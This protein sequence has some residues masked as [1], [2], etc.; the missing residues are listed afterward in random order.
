MKT[1]DKIIELYG[2]SIK[3][4]YYDRWHQYFVN[5]K[6]SIGVTTITGLIDKSRALIYWAVGLT[7]NHLIEIHNGGTTITIEHIEEASKL[8]AQRKKEAADLGTEVHLWCEKY[9]SYM[10]SKNK[11]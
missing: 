8:H 6:K 4:E 1:P 7:K 5:G 11:K 2:G 10:A 9:I 3:V